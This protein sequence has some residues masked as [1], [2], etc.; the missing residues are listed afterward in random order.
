MQLFVGGPVLPPPHPGLNLDGRIS[1]VKPVRKFLKKYVHKSIRI[2][3]NLAGYV[4][5]KSRDQYN[6]D[7]HAV[8]AYLGCICPIYRH[9]NHLYR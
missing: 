2:F 7:I 3:S 5:Q 4:S 9:F 6:T 1:G 8:I